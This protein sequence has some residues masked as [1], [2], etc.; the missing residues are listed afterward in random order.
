MLRGE[1][2]ED[3]A[4]VAAVGRHL[5]LAANGGAQHGWDLDESHRRG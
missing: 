4:D 3:G 1:R 2:P 5:L